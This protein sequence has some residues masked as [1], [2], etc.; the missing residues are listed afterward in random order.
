MP[1]ALRLIWLAS[2]LLATLPASGADVSNYTLAKGKVYNQ[3]N[4][5]G[6]VPKNNVARFFA[7]VDLT[8]T[9]SV[10]NAT[11]QY[12]P[13]GTVNP[14]TAGSGG[15]PGAQDSL[16][17]QA[18]FASQSLLD[19]ALPDGSYKLVIQTVHDGTKSATLGLT[20]DNYP[21]APTITNL[22]DTN[23]N[24]QGFN[25]VVV[26]NPAAPFILTWAPFS[27]GT[28]NDYIQVQLSD[29][30]GNLFFES[31]NPGETGALNGTAKSLVI[32]PKTLP[33]STTV[34]GNLLFAKLV[35]SNLT[36][37]AGVP[38][39]SAYLTGTTF[40]MVT[41]PEDVSAY[42]LTKQQ[43]FEQTNAGAPT[44]RTNNPFH[45]LAQVF[46]TTSNA[47]TYADVQPPGFGA[48]LL[49]PDPTDTVLFLVKRF[50]T[51]TALGTAFP[52]GT[53]LWHISG[54]HDGFRPFAMNLAADAFP[55]A[56]QVT[57]W[58][59]AQNVN[60]AEGFPLTWNPFTGASGFDDILVQAVDSLGNVVSDVLLPYTATNSVFSAGTFQSGQNYQVQVQFRHFTLVDNMTFLGATGSARFASKTFINL[61]TTGGTVPL[62]LAIANTNS[63][64]GP[65]LV[66]TG[67]IGLRYAIDA[68]TNLQSG[69]WVPL[70]TNTAAGGQFLFRDNQSST[71]PVRFYRA[72]AAN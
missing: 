65:Q 34:V 12:L 37:Y 68:S 15:G 59:A 63:A 32:Q 28:V 3:A 49:S 55:N 35:Q 21:N 51:Q 45:F 69:P 58:A 14:L 72:R 62:S 38:G 44:L 11:V 40:G 23:Y 27:G 20:G 64:G 16:S 17:Y 52:A 36:A 56:P 57:D 47:V 6:P 8:Q 66:L 5:A 43:F 71:F 53:Y 29:L 22:F 1:K 18:K 7:T 30:Q 39:Y 9:N 42:N 24:V 46:A 61:S 50:P 25:A 60:P 54:V 70:V 48:D 33:S 41:L 26:S 2:L 31:P 13:S 67:Q 19:A 4:A 10:T